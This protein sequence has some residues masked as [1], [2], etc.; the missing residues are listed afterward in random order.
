MTSLI[1]SLTRT[2]PVLVPGDLTRS[3]LTA[4]LGDSITLGNSGNGFFGGG[5]YPT[6]ACENSGGIIRLYLNAGVAGNTT[7]QILARVG[8]GVINA[9]SPKP[10]RCVVLSGTND[11]ASIATSVSL[12]N[13]AATYDQLRAAGI[14][15][16]GC[17]IP[18]QAA[19]QSKVAALNVGI[20]ALCDARGM[21]CLDFHSVLVDPATGQYLAGYSGDGT[22]PSA[23]GQRT[24]STLVQSKLTP[25]YR[26]TGPNLCQDNTE[27][28]NLITDGLFLGAPTG[29]VAASWTGTNASGTT[30]PTI[31]TGDVNILG[32]WQVLT[33]TVAGS[34][35]LSQVISSAAASPAGWAVGD[36][37]ELAGLIDVTVEAG[38]GGGPTIRAHL[39]GGSA[40]DYSAVYQQ[41]V[42]VTRGV[43]FKRFPVGAGNTGLTIQAFANAPG[44]GTVT[45]KFAQLSLYNLTR[46][47]IA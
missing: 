23:V 17:T 31:Q 11:Q 21:I 39:T 10:G 6:V 1:S 19:N 7:A 3:N 26:P 20:K 14:E 46:L 22:H 28:T 27:S 25:H 34:Y 43:F 29:G 8:S 44:T 40:A 41:T 16:I 24:M 42:D 33:N 2:G 4:F 37:L 9:A 13:I 36:I 15:P 18:P 5:S 45:V 47:G 35:Y 32:N 12:A 30:T 38:V